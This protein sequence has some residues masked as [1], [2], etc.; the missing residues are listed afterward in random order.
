VSVPCGQPLEVHDELL[1]ASS[2]HQV[3]PP[4]PAPL[5]VTADMHNL[6]TTVWTQLLSRRER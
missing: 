4:S 3:S 1:L 2:A 6:W 5:A